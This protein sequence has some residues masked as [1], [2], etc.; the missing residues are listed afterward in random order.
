MRVNFDSMFYGDSPVAI[1]AAGSPEGEIGVRCFAP[2]E[3][4]LSAVLLV[5]FLVVRE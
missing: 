1:E 5:A 3:T 2:P 4:T